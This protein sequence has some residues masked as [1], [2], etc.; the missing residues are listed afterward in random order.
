MPDAFAP[1]DL[2]TAQTEAEWLARLDELADERGSF[3]PLGPDHMAFFAD[4]GDQLLVSFEEIAAIRAQGGDQRPLGLRI[5]ERH[6]L[7]C[8]VILTRARSWFRAPEVFDFFDAQSD[9]AFFDAF[10]QVLFYGEGICGH[11]AAA[12]SLA[13]PG[14]RV[15]C[16]A[17]QATLDPTLAPW[18]R[19]YREARR[20]DFRSRY[21]FAPDMLEAA[22]A[23]FI[24]YDPSKQTE[25]MQATLF[26]RPH[27]TLLPTPDLGGTTREAIARLD[28]TE[29]LIIS[30]LRD[31]LGPARFAD[32]MRKR[33]QD[34]VYLEKLVKRVA[35]AGHHRLTL[36]AAK[37][38]LVLAESRSVLKRLAK[39]E[40]TLNKAPD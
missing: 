3:T 33:R 2:A 8:L 29:T 38:A 19:R 40:K 31:R 9:A 32:M 20:H 21:G 5:A 1:I 34:P 30:A 10:G 37:H 11:A 22:Q 14:A 25:A 18:E 17:P 6:G 15:L 16:I 35:R 26:R 12:F 23:A 7:S 4:G 39:A 13:A 28:L 36:I 24:V 27:V